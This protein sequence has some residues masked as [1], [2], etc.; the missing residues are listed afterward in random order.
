MADVIHVRGEGGSIIPMTLPLQADIAHRLTRGHLR[1]VNP[2]G[3]PWREPSTADVP[4]PP[5]E[6]PTLSAPK[7]AW[8]GWAIANGM[9]A[10]DAEAASKADLI[11]RFGTTAPLTEGE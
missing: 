7:G 5:T 8:V 11:D 1:R 9:E 6:R 2:D 10:D 3:T 4:A